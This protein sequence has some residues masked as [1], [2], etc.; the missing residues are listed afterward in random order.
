MH[1]GHVVQ[2]ELVVEELGKLAY[3]V[4]RD[5]LPVANFLNEVPQSLRASSLL[6]ALLLLDV[7]GHLVDSVLQKGGHLEL[8]PQLLLQVLLLLQL[9]LE[10]GGEHVRKYGQ[11]DGK[12]E[13]HEGYENEDQHRNHPKDVSSRSR[14][15]PPFPPAQSL[16]PDRLADV[17]ARN[18][19]LRGKQLRPHPIVLQHVFPDAQPLLP[20]VPPLLFRVTRHRFDPLRHGYRAV[21]HVLHPVDHKEND[22]GDSL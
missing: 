11:G 10:R 17:L 13:L 2:S 3:L 16:S 19:H 15:L 9:V 20:L 18:L 4:V 22:V 21:Q 6:S 5:H 14:Q 1:P 12:E 7:A 8:E